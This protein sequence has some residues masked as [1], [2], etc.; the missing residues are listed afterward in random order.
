[1]RLR[2]TILP[3]LTASANFG[4]GSPD[5]AGLSKCL[6]AFSTVLGGAFSASESIAATMRC[7]LSNASSSSALRITCNAF[8]FLGTACKSSCPPRDCHAWRQKWVL[9]VFSPSVMLPEGRNAIG[10]RSKSVLQLY[11]RRRNGGI[12]CACLLST[13]LLCSGSFCLRSRAAR[14]QHA[15]ESVGQRLRDARAQLSHA[16]CSLNHLPHIVLIVRHRRRVECSLGN[17]LSRV[18]IYSP[19]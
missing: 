19:P 5:V 12:S 7:S 3:E 18:D 15:L 11:R 6:N 9:E 8:L 17:I 14:F 2:V 4:E 10:D 16:P 1:M 13:R